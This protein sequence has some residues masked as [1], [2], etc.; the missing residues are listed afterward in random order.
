MS[1]VACVWGE[2]VGGWFCLIA[3]ARNTAAHPPLSSSS[4]QSTTRPPRHHRVRGDRGDSRSREGGLRRARDRGDARGAAES[5]T[6]DT[7]ECE[8]GCAQRGR[9]V[10]RPRRHWCAS[11]ACAA[12]GSGGV[13]FR[14]LTRIGPASPAVDR[15]SLACQRPARAL[16]RVR[17]RC[18]AGEARAVR[19]EAVF[20]PAESEKKKNVSGLH[21]DLPLSFSPLFSHPPAT[22]PKVAA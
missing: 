20:P 12:A 7:P 9:P 2:R 6:S 14:M 4:H 17:A 18:R 11:G 3:H 15:A 22:P 16:D 5:G 1:Q 10:S 21:I 13:C 19:G 8:R